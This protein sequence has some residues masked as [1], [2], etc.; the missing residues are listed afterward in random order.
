MTR[1]RKSQARPS[2]RKSPARR[3]PEPRRSVS[4]GPSPVSPDALTAPEPPEPRLAREFITPV[5]L[6][7]LLVLALYGGA[8]YLANWGGNFDPRVTVRG[9]T[10][11]DLEARVPH[12]PVGALRAKGR[13]IYRIYC[14][15]CHQP[16]GRGTPPQFPPL[17]GSEWVT[18]PGIERLVRIVLDGLQGPV[19]VNGRQF[20]NVMLAWRAQLKDEDIAAVLTYVRDHP[21][22]GNHAGPVTPEQVAAIR[23]ATQNHA[24]YWTADQLLALP[25]GE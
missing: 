8:F 16:H 11:A 19:T 24:G 5:W 12:S 23:A 18:A 9:E 15:A 4:S 1:K 17:A 13:R 2:A 21:E 25:P 14:M 7:T 20:N 22:W 3:A 6:L 10:V